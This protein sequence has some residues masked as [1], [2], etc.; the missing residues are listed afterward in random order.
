MI[1][2]T[3][4]YLSW[5]IWVLQWW[6]AFYVFKSAVLPYLSYEVLWHIFSCILET[7][8]D[9]GN[10]KYLHAGNISACILYWYQNN[11]WDVLLEQGICFIDC[12][13]PTSSVHNDKTEVCGWKYT[14]FPFHPDDTTS[15]IQ[16]LVLPRCLTMLIFFYK[17][18]VMS[19]N[20]RFVQW[21]WG[22]STYDVHTEEEG[23]R[24]MW[25]HVDGGRGVRRMWTSTQR[26]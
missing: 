10:L 5:N 25:A 1:A 24:P 21:W 12:D 14:S 2:Y 16:F 7:K 26:I 19:V 18:Y 9:Q 3:C 23:V 4:S 13:R 11:F 8:V 20:M 22:P 6:T 17:N 15:F